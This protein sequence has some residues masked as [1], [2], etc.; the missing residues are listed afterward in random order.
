MHEAEEG[1][2]ASETARKNVKIILEKKEKKNK[3]ILQY[4]VLVN[5]QHICELTFFPSAS[6]YHIFPWKSI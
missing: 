3:N 4:R 2:S 5:N 6:P 1:L